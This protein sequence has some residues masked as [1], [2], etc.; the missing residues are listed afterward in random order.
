MQ[1]A[2]ADYLLHTGTFLPSCPSGKNVMPVT[3]NE[4]TEKMVVGKGT[5]G[6]KTGLN[7]MGKPAGKGRYFR[8][9]DKSQFKSRSD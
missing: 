4:N 9:K 6:D 8:Q 5:P 3:W 2:M 7:G 1:D